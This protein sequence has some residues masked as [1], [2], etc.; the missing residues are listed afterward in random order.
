MK[1]DMTLQSTEDEAARLFA[2]ARAGDQLA[3]DELYRRCQDKV[4]RAVR[5]KLNADAR[6]RRYFDSVD[7]ASDAWK[8][9]AAKCNRFEFD[10]FE[11]LT[12]FLQDVAERKVIDEYR[13]RTTRKWDMRRLRTLATGQEEGG[14]ASRLAVSS[15]PTPS[16]VAQADET[17]SWLLEGLGEDER[18]ALLMKMDQHSNEAIGEE[19][20]WSLRKVQRFFQDL[21]QNWVSRGGR[22]P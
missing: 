20:G 9:L 1:N 11:S 17:K 5:Q 16:Q 12:A 18:Q 8:S 13:R 22:R 2:R 6:M 14:T 21:H 19:V 10:S 3:W 7:F 15:E 4:K